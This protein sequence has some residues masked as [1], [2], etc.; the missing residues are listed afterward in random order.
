MC[1]TTGLSCSCDSAPH[2]ACDSMQRISLHP[3]RFSR[4]GENGFGCTPFPA[5]DVRPLTA[6]LMNAA[7][8]SIIINLS[9]GNTLQTCCQCAQPR[10][11]S[12]QHAKLTGTGRIKTAQPVLRRLCSCY[13][14]P[15]PSAVFSMLPLD[16]YTVYCI[17]F[18][19]GEMISSAPVASLT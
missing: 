8:L 14:D 5:P 18:R 2:H 11:N 7:P 1:G 9:Y 12:T 15:Y 19:S 13:A 6:V 3:S 17:S 10:K 4:T 16:P